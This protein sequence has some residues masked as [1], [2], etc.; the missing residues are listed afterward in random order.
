[1]NSFLFE[2]V[3]EHF[4][5][6]TSLSKENKRLLFPVVERSLKQIFIS[7]LPNYQKDQ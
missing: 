5:R 2:H 6:Q 1:M 4:V 7:F 3:M